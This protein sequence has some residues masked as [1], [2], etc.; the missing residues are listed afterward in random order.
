MRKGQAGYESSSLTS[1]LTLS[2][3]QP[4][5]CTKEHCDRTG[6]GLQPGLGIYRQWLMVRDT[7]TPS[8]GGRK[9]RWESDDW[10]ARQRAGPLAQARGEQVALKKVSGGL[11]R[12]DWWKEQPLA[13]LCPTY[14]SW[15]LIFHT[16]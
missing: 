5:P 12:M 9:G 7:N 3:W 4:L 1:Q 14:G 6:E 8:Y 13:K 15:A 11:G 10:N 2:K 16:R